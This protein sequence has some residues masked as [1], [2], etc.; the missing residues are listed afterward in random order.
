ME[1]KQFHDVIETQATGG[2]LVPLVRRGHLVSPQPRGT[3]PK[4]RSTSI[5][6]ELETG[7][8]V[9]QLRA[10]AWRHP[11]SG[12]ELLFVGFGRTR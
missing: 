4:N 2:N 10:G 9:E 1:A 7:E 11:L 12:E 6:Y 8:A 3:R 5:R